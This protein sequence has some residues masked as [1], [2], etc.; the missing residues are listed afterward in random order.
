VNKYT[1]GM[2]TQGLSNYLKQSFPNTELKVAIA[3]DCRNNSDVFT[4]L[5][6]DVFTANGIRVFL[7]P[8]L[9]PTPQLSFAVRELG[10]QS[11]IVITASHN[12]PEYNGYKVYWN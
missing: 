9:R 7:F 1:L 10:C 12:P 2:A 11:G 6:A 5:V 3:H 4:K 8:S